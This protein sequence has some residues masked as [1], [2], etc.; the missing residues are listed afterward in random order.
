MCGGA[1]HVFVTE[2]VYVAKPSQAP[3]LLCVCDLNLTMSAIQSTGIRAVYQSLAQKIKLES[4]ITFKGF[5]LEFLCVAHTVRLLICR[6]D[7]P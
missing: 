7:W 1:L 6:P 5:F 2:Y 3:S 4:L